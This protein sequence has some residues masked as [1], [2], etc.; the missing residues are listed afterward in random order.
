MA[1]RV[2]QVEPLPLVP[3]T[4]ISGNAGA[5]PIACLTR[6]TRSRPRSMALGCSFSSR[7]SHSAR[8]RLGGKRWASHHHRQRG[9]E[10]VAHLA[11]VDDAVDCALFLQ[12]LGALEAFRQ[13]LAHRLL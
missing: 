3:P 4:T 7:A 2:A 5:R 12:E 1:S 10:F 9:R 11:T 13:R 8:K 6:R